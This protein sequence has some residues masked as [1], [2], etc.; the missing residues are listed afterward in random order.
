MTET[1]K[2]WA[3]WVTGNV[4]LIG[5]LYLAISDGNDRAA[6]IALFMI[7]FMFAVSLFSFSDDVVAV[8]IKNRQSRPPFIA[9]PRWIE[10]P[11]DFVVV[12]AIAAQGWMWSAAAY[13]IHI[14][15][16]NRVR[17]VIEKATT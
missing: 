10:I 15:L 8:M 17:A 12:L 6:N 14:M 2:H 5:S 11:I 13:S 4:A 9:V 1:E 7:W 16:I 3:L